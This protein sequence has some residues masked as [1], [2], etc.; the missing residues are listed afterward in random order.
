[1]DCLEKDHRFGLEKLEKFW[2]IFKVGKQ[3][4]G[5]TYARSHYASQ[6]NIPGPDYLTANQFKLVMYDVFKVK[7]KN[8]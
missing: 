1:M 5:D 6:M 3:D 4:G 2:K 7:R 8:N